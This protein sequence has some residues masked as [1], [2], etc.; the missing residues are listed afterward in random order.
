VLHEETGY[1]DL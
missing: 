1:L